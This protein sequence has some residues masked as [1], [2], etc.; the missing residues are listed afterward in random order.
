MP[1]PGGIPQIVKHTQVEH[2]KQKTIK[3]ETKNQKRARVATLILNR[4]RIRI[5]CRNKEGHFI[6][7]KE[8]IYQKI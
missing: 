5:L 4:N 3:K 2:K 7:I 6:L 8:P 1:S